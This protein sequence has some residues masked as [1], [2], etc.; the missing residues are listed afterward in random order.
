[1]G[2]ASLKTWDKSREG[3]LKFKAAHANVRARLSW[4]TSES[5]WYCLASAAEPSTLL[6]PAQE[7]LRQPRV[8][9]MDRG[10]GRQD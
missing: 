7:T 4:S 3:C 6:V 2:A 9:L 5:W 8:M 10:T 1:M